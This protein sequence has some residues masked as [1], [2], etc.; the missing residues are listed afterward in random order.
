K[1]CRRFTL[2][3]DA[4]VCA[5]NR[6]YKAL[7][8][9]VG[10]SEFTPISHRISDIAPSPTTC[11]RNYLIALY[12]ESVRS[13][14]LMLLFRINIKIAFGCRLRGSANRNG[15]RHQATVAFHHIDVLLRERD[16]H[17]HGR[18]IVR[19]VRGDVVW[20]SRAHMASRCATSEQQE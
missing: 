3:P 9:T 20:P 2:Q 14:T 16:L 1:F 7:M 19:L 10:G 8:K 18:R 5:R 13:R 17:A 15:R 12:A 11:R 6:M 4:T